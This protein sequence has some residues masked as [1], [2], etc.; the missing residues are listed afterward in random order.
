MK[1]IAMVIAVIATFACKSGDGTGSF[2]V[3]RKTDP[4]TDK[5]TVVVTLAGQ[6]GNFSL[7]W[8]CVGDE[9][10]VLVASN[11]P[12]TMGELPFVTVQYRFPPLLSL[13]EVYISRIND[14]LADM[15][16][17]EREG[18]LQGDVFTRQALTAKTVALGM[19]M[20][21]KKTDTFALDGL[22]TVLQE[23]PCA[24]SVLKR[25]YQNPER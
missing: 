15:V 3:T 7:H 2:L 22:S 11:V 6:E 17:S 18:Y 13:E 20:W 14:R 1:K 4:L 9:M 12:G 5:T 19:G 25:L 8:M 23:L 10:S 24:A 21:S 16:L